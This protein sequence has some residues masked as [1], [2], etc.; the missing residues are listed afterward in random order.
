MNTN[1]QTLSKTEV[2]S[3]LEQVKAG[4]ATIKMSQQYK[5]A[6]LT[7]LSTWLSDKQYGEYAPQLTHLISAAHWDYLLD[8]FYQVIPFGTG[9][10]R[11]EVGIG[12]N[13]INAYTIRS[14]AQ[15]HSQY[16]L[17]NMGESAKKRGVVLAYDIRQF[18]T[19]KYFSDEISNP[20]KNLSGKNLAESAAEVYAANGIQV[21]LFDAARTT[22]E[23]SFAV[24]HLN[25][26][27]GDVFSASHNPPEHNGKKVYDQFGGQ[28]T[29]PEDE[30]LVT[31][32]T[33]NISSILSIPFEQGV[34]DGTIK[35]I[36]S[37]VDRAYIE[38]VSSLSLSQSRSLAI[39]FTPLHGCGGSS[40]LQVLR[41]VGFTVQEDPK[42]S[43]PSG[44]FENVTFNIPNP[45]VIQ[46][47]DTPLE[48]A[49]SVNADII[50]NSDPDSDRIG[51][52]VQ[53]HGEW[54]FITGNEIAAILTEFAIGKKKAQL[55]EK[56]VIIKTDVTTNLLTQI[57]RHHQITIVGNLLVGFKYIGE[58]M[59]E[60]EKNGEID[61]L[62]IGCEESHGY[63]AGNYVRDKDAAIAGLWLA[64]C[65]AEL[66]EQG[67]TLI[68]YLEQIYSRYGYFKNYLTE[69]RLPG[70]EGMAQIQDIQKSLRENPPTSFERFKVL[71]VE[72][73]LDRTPILSE[74]DRISKNG[75]AFILQP[76]DGT[77]S[78]RVT[79]RPSGTEPKIKMYFEI[80]SQ[81]FPLENF[82]EVQKRMT[83]IQ[84]EL[85][86]AFMLTCYK[87]IGIDFPKRGFLL[88]WQLPL[89]AKLEYFK[90]E[91]SIAAL[92]DTPAGERAEKLAVLTNFLGSDPLQKVDKAFAAR[93]GSGV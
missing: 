91:E 29:P 69:I 32:V 76:I 85:E 6:A 57:A 13:R 84:E 73:W 80:G 40:V 39:V 47:F 41:N 4:F 75:I 26:A 81:P 14:S 86:Q 27:G 16:L 18:F 93:Y 24:R 34:S 30:N 19:N 58:I 20:V 2:Q 87:A 65:A 59:N 42:T 23:L 67:Q 61:N 21:Y 12:P 60:M 35:I 82:A 62:L 56:A 38:A 92:R 45:E 46:S 71:Q 77:T 51:T 83:S 78:M 9:G 7:N 54:K 11:G 22:P 50:L 25:C 79:V 64:E 66:K 72:D 53:H 88:F 44:K 43:T 5:D 36:S 55:G 10:R 8:C 15:G 63:I 74:T 31:E 3:L 49:K 17:K 90:I 70:A 1:F 48:Y 89:T 28:L 68:D 33:E 37:E 52:M